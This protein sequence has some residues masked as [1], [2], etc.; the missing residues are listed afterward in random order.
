VLVEATDSVAPLEAEVFGRLGK[1][2]NKLLG[3]Y[4][5]EE[6]GTIKDYLERATSATRE[7]GAEGA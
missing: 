6:L 2:M 7:A 3:R 5:D 4:T 1:R